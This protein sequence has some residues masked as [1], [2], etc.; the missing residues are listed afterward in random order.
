MPT[1]RR[2]P[3]SDRKQRKNPGVVPPAAVDLAELST[4]LQSM[5]NNW[6]ALA[7]EFDEID[8]MPDAAV[9]F[10]SIGWSLKM[11]NLKVASSE[12]AP[13]IVHAALQIIGILAYKN[14]TPFSLGRQYRDA[15]SASLMISNERIANK[16]ASMLLV[17]KD[18]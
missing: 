4:K 15:L 3:L 2:Q 8:A 1:G 12:L 17:F 18:D 16:S 14:D 13:V 6:A 11:N 5:R 7:A 10:S 9:Q